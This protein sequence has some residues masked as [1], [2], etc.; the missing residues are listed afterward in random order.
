MLKACDKLIDYKP[1][2]P[3]CKY[4][5]TVRDQR[6]KKGNPQMKKLEV[7]YLKASETIRDICWSIPIGNNKNTPTKSNIYNFSS[8]KPKLHCF[9]H[10]LMVAKKG[11]IKNN[12][13]GYSTFCTDL[14][15]LTEDV[16]LQYWRI[17][18][19]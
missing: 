9:L 16:Y 14:V 19:Q 4:T 1:R 3:V 8:I 6:S 18:N 7:S 10:Y 2:L 13:I 15:L 5:F 12:K 11:H 17:Y